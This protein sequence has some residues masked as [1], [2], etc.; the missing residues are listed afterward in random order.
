MQSEEKFKIVVIE[1][2]PGFRESLEL[3]LQLAE[4]EIESFAS[5]EDAMARMTQAKP[6]A[7]LTDLQLPGMDGVEVIRRCREAD[8]E[9]PVVMMTAHGNVPT[10]VQAMQCGAYDFIEKPFTNERLVST[11]RRAGEKRR[12][13][14]ENRTLRASL[15]EASGIGSILCGTSGIMQRLRSTILRIAPTPADVL[16]SGETGTGKEL[17]AHLIHSFSKRSGNFVAVNCGAI[18]EALFESELFGHEAGA[19]TGAQK[20]RIGKIE[21]A[22]NGTLFLDEIDSL[23]FAMQA[24]LL[25]VLQEREIER[26]GSNKLVP[27]DIR[28]VAATNNDIKA[29]VD[30]GK[31]RADLFYR[32]N[33]VAL[34]LP[35]LRERLE[36]IPLLFQNFLAMA[37]LRFNATPAEPSHEVRER[38]LTHRWPGNVRELKNAAERTV[39]GLPLL[40][41]EQAN[42]SDASVRSLKDSITAI[43]RVL[44]ESALRRSRGDL[45]AVCTELDVTLSSLYRKLSAHGLEADSFRMK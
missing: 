7:V 39:L 41:D 32:L 20:Q 12:L 15:S 10:A 24:K 33:V 34:Q 22:Q 2:Q 13:V 27:V 28:V 8:A 1:D 9:L 40:E 19:F 44:L 11:L 38:L 4:F 18:P 17:V 26:I 25:R 3:V 21:H 35:P 30:Q 37:A 42:D 14:V 31:F 36:D 23:P 43:E 29:L 16:V 5:A 6:D 45:Q